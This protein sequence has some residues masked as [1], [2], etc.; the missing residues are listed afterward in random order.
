M[1]TRAPEYKQINIPLRQYD[2]SSLKLGP[3]ERRIYI[4]TNVAETGLTLPTLRYII[5][6]GYSRENEYNPNMRVEMLLSKPAPQSRLEQR[7]GRVGRKF[8]GEVYPLYTKETYG[9][10]M[11]Q[12]F[13]E[14]FTANLSKIILQIVNDQQKTKLTYGDRS[15]GPYFR[16]S[17]IDMMDPPKPGILV[18]ALERA[19]VLGFISMEPPVYSID[20]EEFLAETRRAPL[21]AIGITK[22]GR[23]ALELSAYIDSQEAIRMILAGFS[24]GY[25]ASD[26]VAIALGGK[27][28]PTDTDDEESTD[29]RV[30][31]S[32]DFAY[33][34]VFGDPEISGAKLAN[35]W[36]SILGDTFVDSLILAAA[37]DKHFVDTKDSAATPPGRRNYNLC[38]ANLIQV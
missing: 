34:E 6:L 2:Y 1:N 27:I 28:A 7:W 12:Q 31:L 25:R 15:I 37:I 8:P 11:K 21:E 29:T 23:I 30:T 32:Y 13:A 35:L 36:H 9:K 16:A 18:D 20:L 38:V 22:M 5:D 14:I 26:L 19:Y 4:F 33:S 24:M 10:L 17:D 3:Y